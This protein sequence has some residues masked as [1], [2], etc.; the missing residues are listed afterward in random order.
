MCPLF[1]LTNGG[2]F[3]QDTITI[4][5]AASVVPQ[6]IVNTA[7]VHT[8]FPQDNLNSTNDSVT[9]TVGTK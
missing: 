2:P 3:G 9:V 1:D 5:V 4:T 6:Q 7:S 8:V